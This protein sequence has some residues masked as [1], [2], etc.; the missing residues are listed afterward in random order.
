MVSKTEVLEFEIWSPEDTDEGSAISSDPRCDNCYVFSPAHKPHGLFD[1]GIEF[2]LTTEKGKSTLDLQSR[3]LFTL[4]IEELSEKDKRVDYSKP[5][6]ADPLAQGT[7]TS[8]KHWISECDRE[9]A[10]THAICS[11]SEPHFLPSRLIRVRPR[12]SKCE[13]KLLSGKMLKEEGVRYAALSYCWGANMGTTLTTNN[14]ESFMGEIPWEMVPKTIQ[15]AALTTQKLGIHYLWV[16]S[17]CI[18]QDSPD[19]KTLE[20]SQ[21]T[22]VYTHATLTIVAKRANDAQ[23]GF[24]HKRLLP[25]GTSTMMF[26]YRNGQEGTVTLSFESA[27]SDEFGT[28]L[29]TRGWVLQEYLLSRRLL[30]IGNWATEWSC[31]HERYSPDNVDGRSRE[32]MKETDPFKYNEIGSEKRSDTLPEDS[33]T[34]DAIAFYAAHPGSALPRPGEWPVHQTWNGL[35]ESYTERYLSEPTDRIK[36]IADLAKNFSVMYELR[37]GSKYAAGLWCQ[38]LPGALLWRNTTR[39]KLP[40]PDKWQGPLWS[41][42]A[43]NGQ[44]ECNFARESPCAEVEHVHCELVSPQAPFGELREGGALLRIR[45]CA[46]DLDWRYTRPKKPKQKFGTDGSDIRYLNSGHTY[47]DAEVLHFLDAR[48][49]ATDWAQITLLLIDPGWLSNAEGIMLKKVRG[50]KNSRLGYFELRYNGDTKG[51]DSPLPSPRSWEKE[52]FEII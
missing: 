9:Q 6:L 27:L 46:I 24:L 47:V 12:G 44:V 23:D 31:R 34:L 36:A 15:H 21:M 5:M 26:R 16:D 40:R 28:R 1:G 48:E 38:D 22:E 43:I 20:I 49:P 41:W 30:V 2:R 18:I 8:I 29:D 11:V 52:V 4:D 45:G 13:L 17:F 33:H 42:V 19:D 37:Y 51:F 3:T 7:I 39:Q 25:S 50:G 32:T 35:V 14:C 10:Q